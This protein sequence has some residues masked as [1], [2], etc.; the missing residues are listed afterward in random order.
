MSIKIALRKVVS[1]SA[2][3]KF[4]DQSGVAVI[5]SAIVTVQMVAKIVAAKNQA[6]R[7]RSPLVAPKNVATPDRSVRIDT[8]INNIAASCMCIKPPCYVFIIP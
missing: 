8:V 6:E 3:I 2:V 5:K 4:F 7:A 1:T